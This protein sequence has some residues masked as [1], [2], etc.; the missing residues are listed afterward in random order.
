VDDRERQRP[1]L[2]TTMALIGTWCLP[3]G[4]KDS[5]QLLSAARAT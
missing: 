3:L 1:R 5:L 2:P 4:V